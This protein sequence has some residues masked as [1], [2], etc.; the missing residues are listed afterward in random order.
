M[1]GGLAFLTIAEASRLLE[2]RELSP[3]E[4]TTALLQRAEVL[5]P[6]LNAYLLLTAERA[7]EQ[8][9]QAEAEIT[10]GNY[11]GPMHGIPFALKDIIRQR[12]SARP[13]IRGSVLT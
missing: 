12:V 10:A 9:H 11:R 4:L 8:A 7:L 3:I 13:A 1:S 2:R 5:D 6:Q